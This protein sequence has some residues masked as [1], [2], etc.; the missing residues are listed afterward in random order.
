MAS[1][2][3]DKG[4]RPSKYQPW[5]ADQAEKLCRLGATDTDLADFFGVTERTI[6]RWKLKYP[7]FCQALKRSKNEI[8]QQVKEALHRRARGY[9][10]TSEKVF[11]YQ[12]QVIRAKTVVHV[13]PDTVAAIFWLK[14]RQ[15]DEWRS[16]PEEGGGGGG[17]G[18]APAL[19]D[20]NPDV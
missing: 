9:S 15:P 3:S 5:T 19:Q 11:Q 13:P 1:E 8:D 12:G 16:N 10:Y 4:G 18:N 2:G 6:N 20:P 7:E 17:E 14:N